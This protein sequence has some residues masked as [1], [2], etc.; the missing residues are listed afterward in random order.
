MG[1]LT[2]R[3]GTQGGHY[4]ST[5][6]H[7]ARPRAIIMDAQMA[8][9][10]CYKVK[11]TCRSRQ[12]VASI[13]ENASLLPTKVPNMLLYWLAW[14]SPS[15]STSFSLGRA[16]VFFNPVW[17]TQAG[18]S[19]QRMEQHVWHSRRRDKADLRLSAQRPGS[20]A[21]VINAHPRAPPRALGAG[22]SARIPRPSMSFCPKI[23]ADIIC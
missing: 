10:M 21:P 2:F 1:C 14:K 6:F 23:V 17:V 3:V 11:I 18:G 13:A 16:T 5:D 7:D 8:N 15:L 9:L 19:A 20:R 12:M 22:I 4:D